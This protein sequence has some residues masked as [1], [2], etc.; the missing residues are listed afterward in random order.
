MLHGPHRK[1]RCQQFFVAVGTCLPIHCLAMIG[2]YTDPQTL[3]W[4]DVDRIKNYASNSSCI[5]CICCRGNGLLSLARICRDTHADT[6]WLKGFMYTIKMGSGTMIY[7]PSFIKIGS[8]I[9]KLIV[10]VNICLISYPKW[11]KTRRCFIAIAFQ[12]CSRIFR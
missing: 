12:L 6:D 9:Q 3:L 11:S 5:A 2:E 8:G 1:Q 4:Y 10:Y 7:V